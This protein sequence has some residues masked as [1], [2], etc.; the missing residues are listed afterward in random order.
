MITIWPYSRIVRHQYSQEAIVAA[1]AGVL[2]LLLFGLLLDLS[3]AAWLICAA[4]FIV[5]DIFQAMCDYQVLVEARMSF[6]LAIGNLGLSLVLPVCMI[7]LGAHVALWCVILVG[8]CG[9]VLMGFIMYCL[10][11]Y[12]AVRRGY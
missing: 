12:E 5:A 8:I 11:S 3:T 1:G 2:M 9:M 6:D 7:L 4:C 10:I